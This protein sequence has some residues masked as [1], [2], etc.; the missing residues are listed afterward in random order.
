MAGPCRI[1]ASTIS[2][3]RD[4][5]R[6]GLIRFSRRPV[7]LPLNGAGVARSSRALLR[8]PF[9]RTEAGLI[10]KYIRK[11]T[12]KARL[13]DGTLNDIHC[14]VIRHGHCERL[15]TGNKII[16]LDQEVSPCV[17]RNG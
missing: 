5:L 6:P 15:E 7:R 13:P 16:V 8:F 12:D 17:Y 3:L 4:I 2:T 11:D 1:I 9:C 14:L 10:G